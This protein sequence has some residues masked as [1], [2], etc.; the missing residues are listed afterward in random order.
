[1]L[2]PGLTNQQKV[3]NLETL[4]NVLTTLATL[5]P[6]AGPCV[7]EKGPGDGVI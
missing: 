2:G 5:I 1:M 7:P 3:D 6:N 4:V